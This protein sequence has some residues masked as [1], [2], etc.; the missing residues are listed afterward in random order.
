MAKRIYTV[1]FIAFWA[2]TFSLSAQNKALLTEYKL[3]NG[4]TVMLWENHDMPDVTGYV[5]VR[6]GSVDE[7]KEYTGLAHY[8]E[9][10]LFKGTQR[11]GALDWEKEQPLY[12]EII[13]LYDT[14]SQTTDP[15]QRDTLAQQIN[16]LSI[17]E[18]QVSTTHDFFAL[19]DEI[20]AVDVNAF[21]T[22]D[23]TCYT[24]SFPAHQMLKWLTINADR[25]RQPVFRTFQ[26]ELEN[27]FEEY[28]MSA[29]SVGTQQQNHLF[30]TIYKGHPYERSVIG[31]PEHLKNPQLSQLINF[32]NTWYVANNMALIL[33]GD[34]S[35]PHIQPMIEHTFG[36]LPSRELPARQRQLPSFEA[37]LKKTFRIGNYPQIYW[38]FE[39]VTMDHEDLPALQLVCQLL[40]NNSG[41]GL[42][43]K[44]MMDGEVS[45]AQCMVDPRRDLGRILVTA[46][47]YFDP[48]QQSFE[49]NSATARIVMN[50][51]D[52]I[53]KGDIPD[54]LIDAVK[55]EIAQ[56][57]T[58]AFEEGSANMSE[59]LSCFIYDIPT[60]RIFT[61]LDLIQNLSK[62]DIRR[63]A[64]KYFDTNPM[65]ITFDEGEPKINKLPK[66][67][68]QPLQIP[69]GVETDYA[70]TFRRLSEDPYQPTYNNLA[71]V[72]VMPVD[73]N[74]RLHYT[75]NT[76]NSLFTLSLRYGVGTKK[77]PMLEYVVQLMN[78]AGTMPDT[79]AQTFRRQ[80]SQL[81]GS[82]AYGVSDNYLTIQVLGEDEHMQEILQLVNMQI[83]MPK[84]DKKQFDAVKGSELSSRLMIKRI[85]SAWPDALREYIVYGDQSKYLDVV[86]F[87]DVYDM[88]ELKM[89][90]QFQKATKYALDVHYC[91]THTPKEVV[92]ALPL[93]EGMMPSTSPEL[94]DKQ[95]Y[96]KTQI[97]FL[98]DP[99]LQQASVYFYQLGEPYDIR[100]QVVMDAFN[101]Y[102]S[103]GFTGIV[104]DEIRTK[105]SLAYSAYAMMTGSIL[106]G[107]PTSFV[108]Y[109][110]TQSDKV[111]EAVT[112]FLQLNQTLPLYP[113]RIQ[114]IKTM[115]RQQW[116]AQ[117]PSM[118]QKSYVYEAWQRL[119]YTDDPMRVHEKDIEQLTF[120]QIQT[121]YQNHVQGRPLAI[122]IVGDPK[123]IDMKQLGKIAKVKRVSLNDLFAPLDLD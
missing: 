110:G 121:Y 4:L 83:L 29:A 34:F 47:P 50:E 57:Y 33:V 39:G 37:G 55:Q 44:I 98:P 81:G 6:V 62:E 36:S 45:A 48:N 63:V 10:M 105:R 117:Q 77:M 119:G 85:H 94:R 58:L 46:I 102:F 26:A 27:V 53:K 5:A 25:M 66:P 78:R 79:D 54:W 59:L 16:R 65:T 23:M 19:M 123:Q 42:L 111:V 100:Q 104:L 18:A 11:I 14:Y 12:E 96:D 73:D 3:D 35:T 89:M 91:G 41:T 115:V 21:T 56:Q 32:F 72:Q 118:R 95:Q 82:I 92:A 103:G 51:I 40:N 64:K 88:D 1:L 69:E 84:L 116:Q 106:P 8:L 60:D 2:M 90:V 49:S 28:N 30:E 70:R 86:P 76:K 113:A 74:V 122:L 71:D 93:S 43:D 87:L 120:D 17:A 52:K 68:I 107:K 75:K 108:G 109:I 112:T 13:R 61:Q 20:G 97:F 24:S 80:L 114:G 15:V 38:V 67:K 101:H 22:Y 99:K 9:H 7:P 31:I